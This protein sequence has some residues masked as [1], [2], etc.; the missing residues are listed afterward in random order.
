[1]WSVPVSYTGAEMFRFMI[2]FNQIEK[3]LSL[4]AALLCLGLPQVE[5]AA[6]AHAQGKLRDLSDGNTQSGIL[7]F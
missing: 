6:A 3:Y 4:K 2:Q 7:I 5:D 1:M